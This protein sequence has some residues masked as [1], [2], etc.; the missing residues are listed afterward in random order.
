MA[1]DQGILI[2]IKAR[3]PPVAYILRQQPG[4]YFMNLIESPFAYIAFDERDGAQLAH[5]QT[6]TIALDRADRLAPDAPIQIIAAGHIGERIWT[7]RMNFGSAR[8]IVDAPEFVDQH[9]HVMT[10][11]PA[12]A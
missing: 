1:S 9:L 6:A 12:R 2:Q 7:S 11:Q 5:G 10:I 4:G 3:Q 8:T